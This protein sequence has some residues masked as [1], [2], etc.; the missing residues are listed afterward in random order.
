VGLLDFFAKRGGPISRRL[1]RTARAVDEDLFD[2]EFQRKLDYLA[3]VSKRV[4]SGAMRAERRTRKTGSGVEFADHRDYAPG[5]DFRYLDWHVWQR[6][7]RLLIR[8]Y[9]EEEDLS[10]YFI[11]DT[12]ASMGFGDG[13]KLRH[14]KRLCA[15]LAYVGLANLDR[16]TIVA[17]NDAI[18][19]RMPETRGKS[20]IFRVFRFLRDVKPTG[21]TDLESALKTFV[22]Q[23]KRRG[24]AV[25]ITDLYDHKGF[26]KGINA[27]RYAKFEPFVLHVVDEHD[28]RPELRG[29][30]R[31]YDCETG[32]ERE[33]TVTPRLLERY[34]QAYDDWLGSVAK[35]SASKQ[36]DYFRADVTIPF[37]ELILRVFRKGGF[38]R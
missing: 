34:A 36:V 14:A 7:G 17:A 13:E 28:R 35:W 27:L 26:E 1:G 15:A 32:D 11:L 5:D 16:V 38:L 2:D 12:S 10:I 29:D 18:E 20:R 9:E 21:E 3:V 25:L 33:V 4:F 30:V 6:M 37:D 19:A 23:H 8:L 24:L 22:A 31:V